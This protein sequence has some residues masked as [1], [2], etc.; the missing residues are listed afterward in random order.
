M[1]RLIVAPL[2]YFYSNF[3][4]SL[5]EEID[6]DG[7]Y[8]IKKLEAALLEPAF[9]FFKDAFSKYDKDDIRKC[10]YAI[11]YEF[12]SSDDTSNLPPEIAHDIYRITQSFR[13]VKRT[14]VVPAILLLR[15][16]QNNQFVSTDAL[17]FQHKPSVEIT[18]IDTDE[19]MEHFTSGNAEEIKRYWEVVKSLWDAHGGNYHRV[20]NALIFFEIGHRTMEYKPRLANLVTALESLFNT[21]KD[22]VTYMIRVRCSYFLKNDPAE[23]IKLSLLLKEIYDLRS[24]FIHGQATPRKVLTNDEKQKELLMA[25]EDIVRNCIRKI[26]DKNLLSLF[27]NEEQLKQEFTKLEYGV[28]SLLQ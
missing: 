12:D 13:L 27:A 23:R 26:F 11:Y 28:T 10:M 15:Q 7:G 2:Y 20:L 4:D 8:K 22:Q 24:L 21:S 9:D 14:R 17:S 19:D 5:P 3:R 25:T 1:N 6:L 18:Y 16:N